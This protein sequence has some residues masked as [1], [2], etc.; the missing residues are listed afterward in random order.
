MAKRVHESLPVDAI[1]KR[2][3]VNVAPPTLES[4]ASLVCLQFL[5]GADGRPLRD[6][7]GLP[8][9][10]WPDVADALLLVSMAFH[11]DDDILRAARCP[12]LDPSLA[13]PEAQWPMP[14]PGPEQGRAPF[15]GSGT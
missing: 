2:A 6:A 14:R 1:L 3:H 10:A 15:R 13:G 9:P 11:R 4:V 8:R 7:R 12:A 5:T